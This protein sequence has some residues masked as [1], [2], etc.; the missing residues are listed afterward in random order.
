MISKQVHTIKLWLELNPQFKPLW[1]L[2]SKDKFLSDVP[3]IHK[4]LRNIIY[5]GRWNNSWYQADKGK[6]FWY[7]EIDAWFHKVYAGTEEH[8]RWTEG[9]EWIKN[10]I[11]IADGE[12]TLPA[13]YKVYYIGDM[14][15]RP[16]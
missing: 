9:I 12:D 1:T 14:N 4:L 11:T 7:D 2:V 8:R 16:S 10:N 6:K 13:Y 15:D 3:T 5:P